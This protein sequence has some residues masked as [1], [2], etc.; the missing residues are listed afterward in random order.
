MV[1]FCARGGG[2]LLAPHAERLREGGGRGHGE[3]DA[4]RRLLVKLEGCV[5]GDDGVAER[6]G[7]AL[8]A[9][10]LN[11]RLRAAGD[12]P[13]GGD[14]GGGALVGGGVGLELNGRRGGG[15]GCRLGRLA[16]G[17]Y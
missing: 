7:H 13:A 9:G 1:S 4:V 10:H 17:G 11:D 14:T 12:L 3:V 6:D 15:G 16:D 8:R 5:A 2:G